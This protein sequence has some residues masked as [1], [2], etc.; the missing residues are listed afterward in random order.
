MTTNELKKGISKKF[1]IPLKD[2]RIRNE[3]GWVHL[4][5]RDSEEVRVQIKKSGK[6]DRDFMLGIEGY[7][8]EKTQVYTFTADDG[9][10]TERYCINSS[11]TNDF[12]YI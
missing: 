2:V 12:K 3:H 8:I 5:I 4:Y 9:Y 11:Y 6:L 1:G 10:G 7:I